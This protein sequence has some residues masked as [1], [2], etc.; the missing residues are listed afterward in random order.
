MQ[1]AG[2]DKKGVPPS[3]SRVC[4]NGNPIGDRDAREIGRRQFL[5]LLAGGM[6]ATVIEHE[7]GLWSRVRSWFLPPM[8]PMVPTKPPPRPNTVDNAV[9]RGAQ[10]EWS[11]R[12]T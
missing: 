8:A 12:R 11:A 3:M 4:G 5:S 7:L 9:A 1:L 6:T 2:R 10:R